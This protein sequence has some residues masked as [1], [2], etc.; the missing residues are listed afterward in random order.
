MNPP[1]VDHLPRAG[2]VA[3]QHQRDGPPAA[4]GIANDD[5]RVALA[6]AE[7]V[8][9]GPPDVTG[10]DGHRTRPLRAFSRPKYRCG[11]RNGFTR[12]RADG[13]RGERGPT[14]R[15]SGVSG[16]VRGRQRQLPGERSRCRRT[17]S[18][19]GVAARRRRSPVQAVKHPGAQVPEAAKVGR[20]SHRRAAD[21][22]GRRPRQ[23]LPLVAPSARRHRRLRDRPHG[24]R[25][26]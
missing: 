10:G 4:V 11:A 25:A 2:V 22:V 5:S 6:G 16:H 26:G 18:S 15:R 20:T 12:R 7:T 17:G 1:Q 21:R 23:A 8:E 13:S 19:P 24:L 14:D 3:S 9:L